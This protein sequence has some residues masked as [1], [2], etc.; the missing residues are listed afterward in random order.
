MSAKK[1]L[2]FTF[3]AVISSIVTPMATADENC[4]LKCFNGG[5]CQH[6]PDSAQF[7][8]DCPVLTNGDSF[9]GIRCE[10]PV[11]ECQHKDG[12]S[13]ICLNDSTCNLNDKSCDCPEEFSGTFCENGPVECFYGGICYNGGKCFEKHQNQVDEC[14][15]PKGTFGENCEGVSLAAGAIA[16]ISVGATAAFFLAV[17]GVTRLCQKK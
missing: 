7:V 12:S 9:T 5:E 1:F 6:V 15:C 13:Y 4:P 14:I 3:M 16:G 2:H 8:C 17:F 11:T 10:T